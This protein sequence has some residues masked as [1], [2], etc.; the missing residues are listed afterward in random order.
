M[1]VIVACTLVVL[2][3]LAAI[4]LTRT[5][6]LSPPA[7]TAGKAPVTAADASVKP[8]IPVK[9]PTDPVMTMAPAAPIAAAESV[10]AA[11]DGPPV[12]QA[13]VAAPAASAVPPAPVPPPVSCPGN[14]DA[15]GL[16]RTVQIDTTG[17]PGFGFEHFKSHDFLKPGEVVLTFDDG[18]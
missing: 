14:P 16:A 4:A 12:A 5:N 18:P 2:S 11:P 17:G 9:P 6:V 15:L 8:N 10:Q 1:R 3:I 13:T 7:P